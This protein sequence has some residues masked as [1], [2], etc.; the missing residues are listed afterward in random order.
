[1]LPTLSEAGDCVVQGLQPG[2]DQ[3]EAGTAKDPYHSM[4]SEAAV[5]KPGSSITGTTGAAG[6]EQL[7]LKE[8]I[9]HIRSPEVLT[10]TTVD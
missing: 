3:T 6:K 9:V 2:I 1:M 5:N 10:F 7:A 4:G 8:P